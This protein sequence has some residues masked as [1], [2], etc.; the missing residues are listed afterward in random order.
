MSI[1][2]VPARS[3][4]T[5]VNAIQ[6]KALPNL[7]AGMRIS[8]ALGLTLLAVAACGVSGAAIAD[9]LLGF[10]VGAGAG[11]SQIRSDDSRYG[12]PGYYNDYQTAWQAI[13]GIR[14]I[15]II[16]V[17]AEYID[18]GQP[19]HH[20]NYDF[21]VSGTDSHPTAPAVFAVGYLPIPIPYLDIFAKVGAAR[22][23]TNVTDFV[24]VACVSGSPCPNLMAVS[25]HQVIDT[26]VAYGAG[27]QSK[28]PFGLIVRGE[29]ERISS[30]YGDPSALMVS[31]LWQF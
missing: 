10:Y 30:P 13:V 16:G 5:Y 28:F 22:L 24:A 6:S 15:S 11:E 14:P 12:L 4:G 27:V 2:A 18:F 1:P 31:A 8:K 17:E 7:E 3:P 29:Y 19:G 26:R 23:S 21:N 25:R 20:H 9:N